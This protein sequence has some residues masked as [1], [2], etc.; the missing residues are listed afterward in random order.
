MRGRGF[1]P[2]KKPPRV[3]LVAGGVTLA[4]LIAVALYLVSSTQAVGLSRISFTRLD[5]PPS[6]YF[7]LN[8]TTARAL[9]P[10]VLA[11]ITTAGVGGVGD[12]R[13]KDTEMQ[14][15]HDILWGASLSHKGTILFEFLYEGRFYSYNIRAIEGSRA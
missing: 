4:I 11:A 1:E 12:A 9:P 13:L 15:V 3:V 10:E 6:Q 5:A 8:E 7:E 14:E 2:V